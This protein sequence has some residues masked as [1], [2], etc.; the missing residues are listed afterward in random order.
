MVDCISDCGFRFAYRE[1]LRHLWLYLSAFAEMLEEATYLFLA[2]MEVCITRLL[3]EV[4]H[5]PV[6]VCRQMM[7][8]N[9]LALEKSVY[10]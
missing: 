5:K 10:I 6:T 8:L 7:L 2:D 4:A 9:L 3:F 1:A